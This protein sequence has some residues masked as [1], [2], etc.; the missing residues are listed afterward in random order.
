MTFFIATVKTF[1]QKI[2]REK[3]KDVSLIITIA[4]SAIASILQQVSYN[5][6]TGRLDL[7]LAVYLVYLDMLDM[8]IYKD[9]LTIEGLNERC[10]VKYC[11]FGWLETVDMKSY[12]TDRIDIDCF[13]EINGKYGHSEGDYTLCIVAAVLKDTVN[14]ET[15]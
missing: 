8:K 12:F 6:P 7:A 4:L 11:L 10:R 3:V 1:H 13:K 5:V 15:G 14:Q 2:P 9:L